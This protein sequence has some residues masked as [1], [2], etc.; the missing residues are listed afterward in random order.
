VFPNL[1]LGCVD[2]RV[3]LSWVGSTCTISRFGKRFRNGQHIFGHFLV[4]LTAPPSL[5]IC[6]RWGTCPSALWFWSHC[7]GAEHAGVENDGV[8]SRGIATDELSR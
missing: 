8:D 6:K 7:G 4:C 5:A 3:G 2:G 1:S